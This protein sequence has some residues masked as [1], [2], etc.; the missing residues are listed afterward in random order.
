[1]R[2]PE[3][4][5][6]ASHALTAL[7]FDS[8]TLP[9]DEQY[10]AY[11]SGMVNFDVSR[12]GGGPFAVRS[13]AWQVGK[14][15]ISHA[16]SD[17]IRLDRPA[18]RVC[19]DRVDHLY[20][21]YYYRG[22]FTF[23]C[24]AGARR[25]SPGSLVVIDMRQ[26][27]RLEI[28]RNENV[29][30]GIPRHLILDRLNGLDPHGMVVRG[31]AASLLGAML[32]TLC[33]T[34]SRT[35]PAHTAAIERMVIDLVVTTLTDALR[36]SEA[37]RARKEALASRARAYI[38]RHLGDDLDVHAICAALAVSRSSLYRAFGGDGG[39]QQQIRSRRLRRIR[40]LLADPAETRSIAMLANA[41]GFADKSHLTRAF[42]K[43][44]GATPG[45]FRQAASMAPTP[46][47]ASDNDAARRFRKWVRD[48][49]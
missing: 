23:D 37:R 9:E 31:G 39:V 48:L 3:G 13:L 16:E 40:A 6:R 38:D 28:E 20:V 18:E 14:L 17:A 15:V 10:A 24:E 43:A 44:F 25:G 19:A 4:P 36:T 1:M 42:K 27:C 34:L 46:R 8:S 32:R 7:R 45:A 29:S 47:A 5:F 11:A 21:N 22:R 12:P 33:T 2:K 41:T 26:P 30:I 49:S 35:M